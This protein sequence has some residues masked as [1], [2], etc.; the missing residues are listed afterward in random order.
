MEIKKLYRKKVMVDAN[1][2]I[3]FFTGQSNEL[4]KNIFQLAEKNYLTLITT[5][6]I[7]DEVCFK[8]MM[9]SARTKLGLKAN[10]LEKIKRDKEKMKILAKDVQKVAGFITQL[11]I[12][13]KEISFKEVQK[14]PLFMEKYGLFGNDALI[15]AIMEKYNLKYLL[16]SDKD[17]D[18]VNFVRRIDPKV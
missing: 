16:S 3:Y 15:L 17:F 11:K 1:A 8:V 13:V 2:F 5:I 7:V 14:L 4:T 10:I 18:L 9:I 6:R 12:D